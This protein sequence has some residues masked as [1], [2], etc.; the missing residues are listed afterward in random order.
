MKKNGYE[1]M[2]KEEEE[3]VVGKEEQDMGKEE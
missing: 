2:A 3:V 1:Q